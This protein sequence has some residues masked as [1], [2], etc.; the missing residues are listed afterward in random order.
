MAEGDD[1]EEDPGHDLFEHYPE[2]EDEGEED[3]DTEQGWTE[4]FITKYILQEFLA[5]L[6][7]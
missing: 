2:S 6:D 1:G 7:L 4:A 3:E 5:L